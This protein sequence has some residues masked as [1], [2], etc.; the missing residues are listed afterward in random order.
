MLAPLTTES[1]CLLNIFVTEFIAIIVSSYY[2][3]SVQNLLSWFQ[4]Q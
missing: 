2:I 1:F 3:K 4:H